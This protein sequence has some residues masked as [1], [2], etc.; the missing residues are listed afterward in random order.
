[1]SVA[2]PFPQRE[3]VPMAL[4]ARFTAPLTVDGYDF[5]AIGPVDLVNVS[6]GYLYRILGYSFAV[7]IP[8]D[9]YQASQ[10]PDDPIRWNLNTAPGLWPVMPKPVPAPIYQRDAAV[11]QYFHIQD[12]A[13]KLQATLSG[14]LLRGSVALLGYASI[15]ATLTVS[16]QALANPAWIDRFDRGEI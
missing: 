3:A 4:A 13:T 11:L 7:E 6:A 10:D 8:E 9:A 14:R 1:M 16:V 2:L 12:T 5:G 15:T